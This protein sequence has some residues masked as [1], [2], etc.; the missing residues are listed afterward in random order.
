MPPLRPRRRSYTQ[1]APF[2]TVS[3]LDVLERRGL[4]RRRADQSMVEH[5]L[6]GPVA[7]ATAAFDIARRPFAP[8]S[9]MV[10]VLS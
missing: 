5:P 1:G 6:F 7:A 3:L 9:Q 4:F 2:W 8:T 10:A